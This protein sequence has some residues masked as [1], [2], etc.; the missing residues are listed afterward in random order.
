MLI[1]P[2]ISPPPQTENPVW[3][4]DIRT[5]GYSER[6]ID[7]LITDSVHFHS[8]KKESP[9]K[10]LLSPL[11]E[12]A[13]GNCAYVRSCPTFDLWGRS[14]DVK[15]KEV[16]HTHFSRVMSSLQQGDEFTSTGWWVHF[17][18]VMSSAYALTI[19][20]WGMTVCV[21]RGYMGTWGGGGGGVCTAHT[22]QWWWRSLQDFHS[23]FPP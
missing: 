23:W 5:Y 15:C 13:A 12:L 18:R 3:N 11:V 6:P 1:P 7:S 21:G 10:K 14:I 2:A 20:H 19:T 8:P 22:A 4:P 17:I 9:E 16:M